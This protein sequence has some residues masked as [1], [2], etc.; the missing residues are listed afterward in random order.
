MDV[1]KLIARV[2][3]WYLYPLHSCGEPTE[4]LLYPDII[5]N[6][7]TKDSDVSLSVAVGQLMKSYNNQNY[8][9]TSISSD[10]VYHVVTMEKV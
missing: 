3:D 8:R 10:R 4:V 7:Y 1:L 6:K 5:M 2:R 9:V